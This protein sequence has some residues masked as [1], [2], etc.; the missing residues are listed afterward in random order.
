LFFCIINKRFLT[1][2]RVDVDAAAVDVGAFDE[3]GAPNDADFYTY[4]DYTE[5]CGG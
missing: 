1:S 2:L 3:I 4:E 5:D